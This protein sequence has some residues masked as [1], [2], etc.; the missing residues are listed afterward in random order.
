MFS[1]SRNVLGFAVASSLTLL[2]VSAT[3]ASADEMVQRLGPVSPQ[4]P[5]LATVGDKHVIAF[6]TP[7]NGQCQVQVVMWHAG[8]L[9]AR[10][11]GG[12]R[13]RLSP[14]QTASIDSSGNESFT[15][16]CGDH[17]E[18]LSSLG[19]KPQFALR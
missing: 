11:A 4:Q 19:A 2:T 6:F 7:D 8:D 17:A 9:E 3:P 18:T 13:V 14:G 5:I 15:L 16:K 10:S 1:L 12:M